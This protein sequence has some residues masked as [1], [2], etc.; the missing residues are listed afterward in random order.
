MGSALIGC[1]DTCAGHEDHSFC[2]ESVVDLKS[3]QNKKNKCCSGH[4]SF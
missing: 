1:L 4:N 2:E 3:D